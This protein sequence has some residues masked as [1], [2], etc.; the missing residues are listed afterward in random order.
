MCNKSNYQ[1]R[2]HRSK[3]QGDVTTEIRIRKKSSEE[4]GNVRSSIEDVK[5]SR[6]SDALQM[7][8][9]R[10]VHQQIGCGTQ[11]PQLLKRLIS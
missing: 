3:T 11:R 8:D 2:S 5:Q 7:K 9:G 4:R 6:S 10:Q 1:E